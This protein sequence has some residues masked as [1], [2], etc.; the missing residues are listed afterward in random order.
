MSRWLAAVFIS[1]LLS[2]L[3]PLLRYPDRAF[4]VL[5]S[6]RE[7]IKVRA[8]TLVAV[9]TTAQQNQKRQVRGGLTTRFSIGLVCLLVSC[10]TTAPPEVTPQLARAYSRVSLAQLQ[11]GRTLF[12]SRCIECHTLPAVTAHTAAE[13]PNLIAEMADRASLKPAE[14]NAVLAYIL[15]AREPH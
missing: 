6:L 12:V 14:R 1:L 13:W 4:C 2:A 5:L 15:A 8:K 11:Q 10:S 7:R 9:D 3:T